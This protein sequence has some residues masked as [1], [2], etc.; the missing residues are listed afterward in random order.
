M[1]FFDLCRQVVLVC[2]LGVVLATQTPP[3]PGHP[4]STSLQPKLGQPDL[5]VVNLES[6]SLPR[7]GG[8]QSV[9]VVTSVAADSSAAQTSESQPESHFEAQPE[10]HFEAQPESHFE[11]Q[12]ESHFETQPKSHFESQSESHFESQPKSHFESQSESHF[13]SQPKSHFKSQSESYFETQPESH[14]ESQPKSHFKSQSESHFEAQPESHFETQPESHFETQAESHFEAQPESHFESHSESHFKAQPESHFEAQPESHFESH[15]ESHLAPHPELQPESH[16]ESQPESQPESHLEPLLESHLEPHPESHPESHLEPHPESQP[17]SQT[18]PSSDESLVR[19]SLYSETLK[20]LTPST[21]SSL[22]VLPNPAF[23]TTPNKLV[24]KRTTPAPSTSAPPRTS[25]TQDNPKD[26]P[27]KASPIESEIFGAKFFQFPSAKLALVKPASLKPVSSKPAFIPRKASVKPTTYHHTTSQPDPPQPTTSQLTLPEPSSAQSASPQPSLPHPLPIQLFP[28]QQVQ[29]YPAHPQPHLFSPVSPHSGSPKAP[30]PQNVG[31][32]KHEESITSNLVLSEFGKGKPAQHVH[33]PSIPSQPAIVQSYRPRPVPS[34]R[35]SKNTLGFLVSLSPLSLLT[36]PSKTTSTL[37]SRSHPVQPRKAPFL[38]QVEEKKGRS[39]DAPPLSPSPRSALKQYYGRS[40]SFEQRHPVFKTLH[41]HIPEEGDESRSIS[42][43]VD[44]P[45][46]AAP[47]TIVTK[48]RGSPSSISF[49]SPHF[50][51]PRPTPTQ[52]EVKEEEENHEHNRE[53]E[54]RE[55]KEDGRSVHQPDIASFRLGQ[56]RAPA[57]DTRPVRTIQNPAQPSLA[58]QEKAVPLPLPRG[59]YHA[60]VRIH[61]LT[62]FLNIR[63][64]IRKY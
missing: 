18:E 16:L 8:S 42:F 33:F 30:S 44:P 19:K 35:D 31:R 24:F 59:P 9:V 51:L 32:G 5:E 12:T 53:K 27:F 7:H 58:R 2:V 63:I 55:N 49:A 26:A 4:P 22:P 13:E 62:G 1:N 45:T 64:R 3:Q 43:S 56:H 23:D 21:E 40:H 34:H 10:S 57:T 28:L 37:V 6:T 20:I 29:P 54:Q 17:E 52:R 15:S 39:N 25:A 11:S 47:P 46:I 61:F 48:S 38:S 50:N 36:S 14:F 41:Q 60:K